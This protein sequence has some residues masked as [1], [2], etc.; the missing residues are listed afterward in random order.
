MSDVLPLSLYVHFPWCVH[1][2]PYCDFNSHQV[3]GEPPRERYLKALISD[4]E[5]QLPWVW[6]RP[7]GSIFLGGGTPS[8][9]G[10]ETVSQLLS[11][12]R[13]RLPL[14]P[15]AEITLEA[16]PGTVEH[17]PLRGYREAGVNRLSLGI[18]SLND[19]HLKSL[20]RIHDRRQAL[21]AIEE[22][23]KS[24]DNFN[25]DLMHG[26]PGQTLA[27]ALSDVEQALAQEPTH[28]SCY[29]LTLEPHTRFY[30]SP[31]ALPPHDLVADMGEA[32]EQHL[33]AAGWEHYEVSAY[34]RPGRASRHNLNYWSFG[35]YLGIGAGAHGKLTGP[36]GRFRTWRQAHPEH[37]MTALEA[38]QVNSSPIYDNPLPGLPQVTPVKEADL[39]FE[40]VMNALRLNQ[41]FP[42]TWFTERTGLPESAWQQALLQAEQKGWIRQSGGQVIPTTLGQR[43][44]NDL[45][46]LF[47]P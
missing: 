28:L 13:Q 38:P 29:Q 3:A 1:K 6:G 36:W 43:F 2:C 22:A 8:L 41:G 5:S 23:R 12:I 25:L 19:Q 42:R 21:L 16:N 27:Q 40:F 14:L 15:D 18:Q 44:L 39:P 35:D 37:Y 30:Q 45:V 31:P 26:L 20:E 34:S 32:I 4:L 11:A 47:L 24:F 17:S 33:V 46:G 9:M 7:V 10:S